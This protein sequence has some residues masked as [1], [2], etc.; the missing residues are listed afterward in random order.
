MRTMPY[1]LVRFGVLLVFSI[2]TI[3]WFLL[4]FGMAAG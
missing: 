1:A 3:V 2:A 4:T